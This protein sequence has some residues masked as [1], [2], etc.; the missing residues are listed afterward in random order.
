MTTQQSQ[1][2]FARVGFDAIALKPTECDVTRVDDLSVDT[3]VIDYEG[4]E[5][6]PS[7]DELRAL[8]DRGSVYLTTPVRA[9]GFDPLG[10]DSLVE[11]IPADVGRI[12][13]A[14]HAAY[15]SDT[16]QRR[17]VAPRLREALDSATALRPWVGT[18]GIKRIALAAGGVQYELLTQ[19]TRP[20]IRALRAAGYDGDV[21][22]Y[23]PTVLSSEEDEILDAVGGYVARRRTV[24]KSLAERSDEPA[25]DR[26]AR[27]AVRDRLLTAAQEFALVGDRKTIRQRIDALYAAGV[28]TVVGYPAAGLD[29]LD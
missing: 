15:L 13:V 8:A 26:H 21:S 29:G 18:A 27:G 5:H 28:D 11:W 1:Q 17:A 7:A 22:V 20:S 25:T 14:G 23:A 24:R 3:V 6:L 4:R 12:F 9:D 2:P 19:E 16:E 10:D